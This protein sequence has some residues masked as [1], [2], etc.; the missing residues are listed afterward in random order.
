MYKNKEI[1]GIILARG[2]SKGIPQKNIKKLAGKPLISYTIEEAL[3]SNYIDR[4]ILSTDDKKIVKVAKDYEVEIPF[5]RPEELATDEANGNDAIKHI[6]NFLNKNQ[7]YKP[8]YLINLQP[9]SPLRSSKDIDKAIRVFFEKENKFNSLISVCEA[10]EN[11]YWMHTIE[12]DCLTPLMES[13]D[14][15]T[16]RQELPKV[17]QPNGAIYLSTYKNFLK[18]NTFYTD[19]VYPYVMDK[20]KSIDID[21]DLDWKLAEILMEEKYDKLC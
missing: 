12:E 6:L 16:R 17:Y 8:N 20:E 9:T 15:F 4:L 5:M 3:K 10:F 7:N 11:P 19:T 13:F 14:N 2:G 18:F 21:D 1:L